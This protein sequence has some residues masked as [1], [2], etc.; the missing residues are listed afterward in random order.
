MSEMYVVGSKVRALV[1][2][3]KMNMSGDF[4]KDLSKKVEALVKEACDRA[5]KNGRKTLRGYDL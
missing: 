2:K 1:K 5:K 3:Q 4:P